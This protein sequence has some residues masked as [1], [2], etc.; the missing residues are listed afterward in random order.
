MRKKKIISIVAGA[1]L[2]A[3]LGGAMLTLHRNIQHGSAE[4]AQII[5]NTIQDS[6][7]VGERLEIPQQVDVNVNGNIVKAENGILMT[8]SGVFYEETSQELTEKGTYQLIYQ[9]L[10]QGKNI[11]AV[12]EIDVNDYNWTFSSSGTNASFGELSLSASNEKGLSFSLAEGESF[13]Y[14]SPVNIYD[15]S[16]NGVIDI[17]NIYP[18]IRSLNEDTGRESDVAKFVMVRLVDC[19]DESN[20]VEF[21]TTSGYYASAGA[22]N[23]DKTGLEITSPTTT[24]SKK[25]VLNGT[26]YL[27]HRLWAFNVNQTQYGTFIGP[28]QPR[29]AENFAAEGGISFRWDVKTN[30]VYYHGV[31]NG[32]ARQ[33]LVTDLDEPS[34]YGENLFKGF[35]TGEV[36]VSI[37]CVAYT[38]T[39]SAELQ[40]ASLL[41]NSGD[42]LQTQE[43]VD[44]VAP[45]VQMDF[46]QTDDTGIYAAVNEEISIPSVTIL[47]Q[48]YTGNLNVR[49]YYNYGTEAQSLVYMKDGK[50][51]PTKVGSYT[52]VYKATDTY[53][54]VGELELQVNCVKS[55]S[56]I[57]QDNRL[58]SLTAGKLHTFPEIEVLGINKDVHT[59]LSV[60]T[61]NGE[62]IVIE[63]GSFEPKQVGTYIIRYTFKDNVYTSCFEY[64]VECTN[65][66]N[67][68]KFYDDI[69]LPKYF[70]KNAIYSIDDYYA[71]T[72]N[73]TG[74]VPHLTE[75]FVSLDGSDFQPLTAE[76]REA[77]TVV[78]NST[79]QFSYAYGGEKIYSPIYSVIDV[80][81]TQTKDY[82]KYFIGNQ[83]ANVS[84]RDITFTVDGK[85]ENERI[86]FINPISLKNFSLQF[87][88]I[89]EYDNFEALIIT[90]EDF[91]KTS[92]KIDITMKNGADKNLVY[93][94]NGV[95]YSLED[96]FIATHRIWFEPTTNEI[97]TNKNM[98]DVV[99]PFSSDLCYLSFELIGVKGESKFAVSKI[100][101]QSIRS[102]ANE[103]ALMFAYEKILGI[104]NIGDTVKIDPA[105]VTSVFNPV[106]SK[107]ITVTVKDDLGNVLKDLN[108]RPLDSVPANVV[109]SIRLENIGTY[110]I[111]YKAS[112]F[113][114][115]ENEEN[116]SEYPISVID[117]TPPEVVFK[118]GIDG[119]VIKV[120]KGDTH[121]TASFTCSDN[122]TPNEELFT[123]IEIYNEHYSLIAHQVVGSEAD[124]LAYTFTQ[125]GSYSVRVVCI[126]KEWNITIASYSVVVE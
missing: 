106:L 25:F 71:Y 24:N 16:H 121:T 119:S 81:Y 37:S 7:F 21:C 46:E 73:E 109:Y 45:I 63:D 98:V 48:H 1:F 100:N 123:T 56:F 108:G 92:N 74:L 50:F 13:I 52:V 17:C 80:D 27:L 112:C 105:S 87:N 86:D 83:T 111:S 20:Y 97:Q 90:L 54:N 51:I 125:K 64:E 14:Q 36:Y 11:T 55:K 122:Y 3:S 38:S 82:S 77:Y 126:D 114:G 2:C 26:T 95:E 65:T 103:A 59:E 101:N 58:L 61:P 23:Q 70:I 67:C 91:K 62:V 69:T 40:V 76:K 79:I 89:E 39:L 41:G 6:Y 19:Y 22:S 66:E 33:L 118:N 28:P 68:I 57:Y 34:I 93:I 99:S 15:E 96:A 30:E 42:A 115:A 88:F 116:S 10:Y 78:A 35:T 124:S 49:V 75:I 84:N 102:N 104:F 107:D 4:E 113:T 5:S 47:D 117:N 12:K 44:E 110:W 31:R 8:P 94:I 29:T 53:G 85:E 32:V 60:I 43:C 18:N 72:I 9:F 120:K